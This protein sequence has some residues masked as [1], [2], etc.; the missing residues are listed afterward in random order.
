MDIEPTVR[1]YY[2]LQ[3]GRVIQLTGETTDRYLVCDPANGQEWDVDIEQFEADLRGGYI[4]PVA[5]EWR[6]VS[7]EPESIA[8][9]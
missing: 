3:S 6:P 4:Q 9:P 8:E 7:D 5:P 2:M 1:S